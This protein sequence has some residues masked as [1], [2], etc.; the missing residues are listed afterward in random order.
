VCTR[1]FQSFFEILKIFF[2]SEMAS[3]LVLQKRLSS[4]FSP[5]NGLMLRFV[6]RKVYFVG[7][8]LQVVETKL[9]LDENEER[10]DETEIETF[11][12]RLRADGL[13]VQP[14]F[15]GIKAALRPFGFPQGPGQRFFSTGHVERWM[16]YHTVAMCLC[17]NLFSQPAARSRSYF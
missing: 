16:L 5:L 12:K 4:R 17:K 13:R 11:G 6:K 7:K 15:Q 14:G 1:G 3:V 2:L 10:W 9:P 8:E